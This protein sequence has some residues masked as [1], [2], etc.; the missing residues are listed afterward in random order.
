MGEHDLA[1]D[2]PATEMQSV[3]DELD[4][5]AWIDGTCGL[6]RRAKI[7]QR[8]DLLTELDRLYGELE[9]VKKIPKED[10]GVDDK[11][12]EQIQQEID[13]LSVLAAESA[14]TVH[15]QDRTDERRKKIRDRLIKDMDANKDKLTEEQ[16]ETIGLHVLADAMI[17][18]EV[19]GK[20]KD[21]L[22]GGFPPNKLREIRDRVGD[23]G[24]FD[25]WK[26]FN[27]VTSEAPHVSAP[28]SRPSS[29]TPGG[30]T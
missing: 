11:G 23:S 1:P 9:I 12:P 28:L 20:S 13:D 30:I 5:D 16:E 24:L 14:M 22:P 15:I 2:W 17:R 26:T 29:S 4:L 7:Y 3:S 18:V 6:T 8:G 27:R 10:R 19:D 25:C 21:L